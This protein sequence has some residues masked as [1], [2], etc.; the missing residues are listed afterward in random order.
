MSVHGC[1]CGKD[2]RTPRA[3]EQLDD[4]KCPHCS[5]KGMG[6]VRHDM[7]IKY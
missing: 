1:Y 3:E 7:Q 6:I 2:Y 4:I 5:R